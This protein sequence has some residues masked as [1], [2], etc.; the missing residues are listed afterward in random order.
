MHRLSGDSRRRSRHCQPQRTM[1]TPGER[2]REVGVERP[3]VDAIDKLTGE[4][5]YAG[6]IEVPHMLH[7]KILRSPVA[8]GMVAAINTIRAQAIPGVVAVLTGQDLLDIDPY[9]GHLIK[10]RPI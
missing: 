7:G 9:F 4:A 2:P 1:S 3:R 5:V 10:D 8:H 6:D